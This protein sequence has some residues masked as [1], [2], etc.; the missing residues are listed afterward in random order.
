M[1]APTIQTLLT[2]ERGRSLSRWAVKQ[3]EA[4]AAVPSLEKSRLQ[5]VAADEKQGTL[6]LESAID[7]L[8]THSPLVTQW[9]KAFVRYDTRGKKISH[10]TITIRGQRLE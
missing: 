7:T 8:P 2:P 10:V 6:L 5:P 3:M 4:Y 1:K 9:L